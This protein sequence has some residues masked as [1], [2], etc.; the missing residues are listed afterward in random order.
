[1]RLASVLTQ[2]NDHNLALAAQCGIEEITVRY[3]GPEM[4][5]LLQ[6]KVQIERHGMKLGIIESFATAVPITALSA[7]QILRLNTTLMP[8]EL[9]PA[10]WRKIALI[11]CALFY[12]FISFA[13]FHQILSH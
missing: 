4:E 9:R 13:M 11:L 1:M 2:L 3:P 8:H 12:G 6:T 5:P 7:L 10:L